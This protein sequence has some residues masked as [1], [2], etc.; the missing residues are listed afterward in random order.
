MSKVNRGFMFATTLAAVGFNAMAA[1]QC[2]PPVAA[3]LRTA[4]QK[5]AALHLDKPG[6]ARVF[7]AD[8][9]QYTAAAVLRMTAE[10]RH[11]ERACSRGDAAEASKHL[12]DLRELLR[13]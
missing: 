2:E 6:Q 1:A 8:G 9:S 5:V 13:H 3:T 12:D 7:A 4:A 10:L 11:A